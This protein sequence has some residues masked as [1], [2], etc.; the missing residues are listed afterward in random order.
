MKN[1]NKYREIIIIITITLIL[2]SVRYLFIYVDGKC[3]SCS[4]ENI[5]QEFGLIRK[6][7]PCIEDVYSMKNITEP[8]CVDFKTAKTISD[9]NLARFIDAREAEDYSEGHIKGAV[10]FPYV[11][12]VVD[13]ELYLE[14]VKENIQLGLEE[15]YD[16]LFCIGGND[17]QDAYISYPLINKE[18]DNEDVYY[19]VYCSDVSCSKSEELSWWLYKT[20]QIENV[21]YYK[22]GYK[23]W[24]NMSDQ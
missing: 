23:E 15:C 17:K 13:G 12:Y 20:L 1:L 4:E 3:D 19:V 7:P 22:G 9:N 21:L 16:E 11:Q 6:I 24:Q 8:T 14:Y 5:S 10:N 18:E 2:S